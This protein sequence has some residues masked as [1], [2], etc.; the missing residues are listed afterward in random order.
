MEGNGGAVVTVIEEDHGEERKI[1][2]RKRKSKR[3]K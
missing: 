1:K 3:S 2:R